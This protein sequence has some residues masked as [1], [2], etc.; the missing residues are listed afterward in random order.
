ML[1]VQGKGK[2]K[3]HI[4]LMSTNF[5][6]QVENQEKRQEE[7]H[8]AELTATAKNDEEVI[9]KLH[10]VN[11]ALSAC[12]YVIF[13]HLHPRAV[14]VGLEH[15]MWMGALSCQSFEY[16]VVNWLCCAAIFPCYD[17]AL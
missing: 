6:L 2:D 9:A 7:I 14:H 13:D 12:L 8:L 11:F 1:Q 17:K 15:P 16:L 4:V 3:G 5:V 10:K